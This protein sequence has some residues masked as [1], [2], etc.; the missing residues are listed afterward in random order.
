LPFFGIHAQDYHLFEGVM[1]T[2]IVPNTVLSVGEEAATVLVFDELLPFRQQVF[3]YAEQKANFVFNERDAFPGLKAAMPEDLA[4]DILSRLLPSISSHYNVPAG[5]RVVVSSSY[6]GIVNRPPADLDATQAR[7]HYDNT[8]P[9]ALAILYYANLGDF[10]GTGFFR[11]NSTGYEF[12]NKERAVTYHQAVDKFINESGAA[13]GYGMVD[14][15]QYSL[16]QA[17]DYAPNRALVY[18]SG[19]LHSGL[20]NPE[21][22]IAQTIRESRIT[23]SVFI[24]FSSDD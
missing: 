11:H 13:R 21:K 10:G 15:G 22:D 18:P 1:K 12:I 7:P 9:N 17:I 3:E 19:L 6:F 8:R 14:D 5:A 16:T 20:I 2:G 4:R 23:S 24:Y